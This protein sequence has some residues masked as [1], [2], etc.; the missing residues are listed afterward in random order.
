MNKFRKATKR[1]AAVA[2]SVTVASSS[3]FAS[4]A[5]YPQNFVEDGR[6]VGDI[7]VG[8]AADPMDTIAAEALIEDLRGEFSG[9]NEKVTI[10]YRMDSE[11]GE[12]IDA[13]RSSDSLNY[14]ELLGDV[15]ETAGFDDTDVDA[16]EDGRLDADGGR[17]EDYSQD[18][19][20]SNGAFNYALRDEVEGVDEISNNLF[21]NNGQTFATYVLDFNSAVDLSG[22]DFDEDLIGSELMIMGNEFTIAEITGDGSDLDTLTLVGGSNKVA[23]GEGESTSITVDGKSYEIEVLN[24]DADGTASGEVLLS[25]NGVSQTIDEFDTQTVAGVEIAVTELVGSSRDSVKGYA[26]IVIGG[27]KILL[28]EGNIEVNEEKIDD[29]FEEYDVDVVFSGTGMEVITITYAV[30]EDVVLE[31]NGDSLRDV[32]F[33][34]FELRLD[35]IND[36]AYPSDPSLVI[37]S[38]D[39]EITF[40]GNLLSGESFPEEL[41]FYYDSEGTVNGNLYLA[42]DNNGR[43]FIGNSFLNDSQVDFTSDGVSFNDGAQLQFS[44]NDTGLQGDFSF[45]LF[46]DDEQQYLYRFQSI[47]NSAPFETDLDELIE[48]GS[49]TVD[50]NEFGTGLDISLA[51]VD[52]GTTTVNLTSANLGNVVALE[53]E[54]LLTYLATAEDTDLNTSESAVNFQVGLDSSDVSADNSAEENDLF[55]FTIEFPTDADDALEVILTSSDIQNSGSLADVEDGNNDVREYVTRYGLRAR[56]DEDKFSSVE[57]WV[58]SEQIEAEV[59]LVFGGGASSSASV[60]V[61]A[62]QEDAK[63]EELEDMGYTIT[64]TETMSSE[65]VEFDVTSPTL[66]VDADVNAGNHIVVGG[67]AVNAA[68]RAYLGI[69]SYTVDQ[70]GVAP[71]EGI[72]RYFED[73]N[74]VLVYGYSRED[75]M[76]AVEQLNAGGLTGDEETVN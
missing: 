1:I 13:V 7:V 44:L 14:G 65:E 57:I 56:V 4:L 18:L 12:T 68:A 61:D 28:E 40:Q 60:T 11:G 50:R 71:G 33:D 19:T 39:E 31:E 26:E 23:L 8:S 35:G 42:A 69:D 63:K 38:T 76:A 72:I 52:N 74:S 9:D 32:L 30:D 48:D 24:V 15:T 27:Q 55:N 29:L 46:D 22:T 59:S 17:S 37:E 73:A 67:P 16:L 47:D 25:V 10:S 45:L 5:D 34:A 54:L 2:A 70:A 58:P 41:H 51:G 20:L 3:V 66:D 53:N 43:T 62:D 6:F 49:V 36:D 21:Y 75:T 64:E